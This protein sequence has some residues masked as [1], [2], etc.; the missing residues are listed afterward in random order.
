MNLQPAEKQNHDPDG[1]LMLHSLFQTIQGEGPFTGHRA[2]FIRLSGCNLQ[3]PQCDT[4]YTS[5]RQMV[6]PG[7]L[8]A[9]V[10]TKA[11]P[12]QLVVITGGEPFRQNL[13]PAID[14]LLAAGYQIQIETNGTLYQDLPYEA[15]TVV[16]SPKTGAVH[17]RL[18]PRIAALKYVLSADSVAEDDGLPTLALGHTAS[19][20]LA[21]PPKG[22][23][24]KVYLQPVD[25]AIPENN[26]KHLQA[27]VQSVLKHGYILCLQTHKIAELD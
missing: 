24:G 21:R 8:A 26:K 9:M 12:G 4:E 10:M 2:L 22:F 18:E 23:K 1:W 20:R 14:A 3:C 15:I 13:R 25:E 11:Q 19:P 17:K 6:S 16:C 7:A 27:V 5:N